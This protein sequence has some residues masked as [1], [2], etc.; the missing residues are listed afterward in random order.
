MD[1][2]RV[3]PYLGGEDSAHGD[4]GKGRLFPRGTTCCT[5]VWVP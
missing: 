1:R 4:Y 3:R 5:A 2:S